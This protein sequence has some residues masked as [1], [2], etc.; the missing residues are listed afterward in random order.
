[1]ENISDKK[2][3]IFESML[4][5]I[6]EH[7]FHGAPMSLVAKNAGVAAG[8]IY[9]Y[10]E[11]K[12]QLICELYD[13]N[14]SKLVAIVNAA[15]D[16]KTSYKEKFYTIWTNLYEFY[17]QNSNVLIFFEQYINSPYNTNKSPNYSQGELFDFFLEGIRNGQIKAVKPEILM[18]LTLGSISSTAKLNMFG[19]VPLYKAD[20]KQVV[21]ILWNGIAMH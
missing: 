15:I 2:R 9:H 14:K 5:L 4:D 13:Y 19:N 20:L 3:A 8:T 7:G 6:K 1:M 17:L 11:S 16:E 10:F 18:I 12:D 21:E